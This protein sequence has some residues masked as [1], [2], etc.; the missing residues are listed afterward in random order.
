MADS[1]HEPPSTAEPGKK[2]EQGGSKAGETGGGGIAA[3]VTEKAKDV[4]AAVGEAAG[5]A[6]DKVQEWAST[7]VEKAGEAKDEVQEWAATATDKTGEAVKGFGRELTG[8]IR[9]HPFP[10]LLVGFGVGFMLAR[11]IRR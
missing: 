11:M 5:Q 6:K 9:R 3:N 7:A 2:Q 8:L 10:A 4:V 1:K